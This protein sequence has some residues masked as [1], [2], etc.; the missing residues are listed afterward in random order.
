METAHAPAPVTAQQRYDATALLR[1]LHATAA[2]H[3]ITPADISAAVDL[4]AA[5]L[6]A[7]R[8]RAARS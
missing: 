5:C 3:G 7:V 4:P 2:R 6:A 8:A 1:D